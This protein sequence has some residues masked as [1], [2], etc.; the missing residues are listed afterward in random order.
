[1]NLENKKQEQIIY[2][3]DL[4]FVALYRWKTI[5]AVALLL[6]VVIG[7]YQVASGRNTKPQSLDPEVVAAYET[8]KAV[9]EKQ[10][11]L[12]E[13]SVENWQQYLEE[14]LLIRL[15]PYDHYEAHVSAFAASSM[16]GEAFSDIYLS[17]SIMAA[18]RAVLQRQD[19]L[20]KI[21]EILG[22]SS[23]YVQELVR[24]TDEESG[25]GDMLTVF[26]KSDTA[27]NAAKVA[28]MLVQQLQAAQPAISAAV[29]QHQLQ[30]LGQEAM[31]CSDSALMNTQKNGG[32][33]TITLRDSLEEA[34]EKLAQLAEP[35]I[36][37][38]GLNKAVIPAVLGAV[39]GAFITICV[40]WVLHITDGK[41]YSGRVLRGRTGIKLLGCVAQTLPKSAVNRWLRKLEGRSACQSFVLPATDISSCHTADISALL[42][43]GSGTQEDRAAFKEELEKA[44]PQV[45]IYDCGSLIDSTEARSKL[46]QCCAAVLVEKCGVSR[47]AA[48]E[49]QMEIIGDYQKQLLGCVLLDG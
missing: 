39:V 8:E 24:I 10:V 23:K 22:I 5:V 42:I 2:I 19:T 35:K 30:I 17:R 47:Y 43:T 16:D 3:K 46:T 41:I 20:D 21:G 48:V 49:R 27:D 37:T 25:L 18:Y 32:L 4:I 34:K 28:Y 31:P 14:S 29:K 33:Q 1:M 7:V 12:L 40:L 38:D 6:A 26:V 9:L 13:N 15:D 36:E 44:M 11:Q 45:K